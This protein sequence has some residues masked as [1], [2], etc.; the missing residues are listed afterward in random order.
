MRLEGTRWNWVT[1]FKLSYSDL[2]KD[3]QGYSSNEDFDK[4]AYTLASYFDK[5]CCS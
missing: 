3:W 2:G 1:G 4:V 5:C